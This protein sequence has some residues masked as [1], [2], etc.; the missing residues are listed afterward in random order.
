MND[1]YYRQGPPTY[2]FGPS[3]TPTVKKL[4]FINAG[5]FIFQQITSSQIV[6]LFGL[7]PRLVI[8]ELYAW[9]LFTYQFLH[10]GF[11]HI[12]FN[13]FALWMFGCELE[14]RWGQEFFLK[15]YLLCAVWAGISSTIF[16]PSSQIPIIGASGAVYGILLAYGLYFPE[17]KI[18]IYFLFP[19]KM[20]HFL[21]FIG[22]LEFFSAMSA[23][24]SGIAHLA[25]LGG[26]VFGFFYL[27][28]GGKGGGKGIFKDTYL[29]LKYWWIRRKLTVLSGDDDDNENDRYYH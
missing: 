23:T 14:R 25:H 4:I 10:G 3:I 26:M 15:Y 5:V 16:T 24:N 19:M 21:I 11:F 1:N 6:L 7:V 2:S 20:K 17:R 8:S 27:K 18:L 29:R 9:Q 22:A 13:M 28:R 12:L